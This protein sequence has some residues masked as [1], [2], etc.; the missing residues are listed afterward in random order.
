MSKS[1]GVKGMGPGDSAGPPQGGGQAGGVIRRRGD[2]GVDGAAAC[3]G[4]VLA[5]LLGMYDDVD[6]KVEE[7]IGGWGCCG[8]HEGGWVLYCWYT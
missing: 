7:A 1:R 3:E 5:V 4:L 2:E 6:P 8:M